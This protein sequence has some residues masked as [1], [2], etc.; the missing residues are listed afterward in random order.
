MPKKLDYR[1]ILEAARKAGDKAAWAQFERDGKKDCGSCGGAMLALNRGSALYKAAAEMGLAGD[2]YVRLRTPDGI[3]TQHME[4]E[5]QQYRAFRQA[6]VDAGC[7]GA[8]TK[9]WTYVD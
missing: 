5:V 4:V 6:L 9:F 8:V 2:G 1:A 3:R 7:G